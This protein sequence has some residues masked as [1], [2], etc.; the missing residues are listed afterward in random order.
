MA[1]R[2]KKNRED[3]EL[4]RARAA[5]FGQ[6]PRRANTAKLTMTF[7]EWKARR[8]E[9]V[10]NRCGGCPVFIGTRTQPIDVCDL[11]LLWPSDILAAAGWRLTAE[12]IVY[13]KRFCAEE[14]HWEM[15]RRGYD[16][17]ND[18]ELTEDEVEALRAKWALKSPF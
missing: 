12:D 3:L 10:P 8:L 7:E 16:R 13:S 2:T 4:T 9:R 1:K 18:R 14:P 17:A 5:V 11:N 15:M 6:P